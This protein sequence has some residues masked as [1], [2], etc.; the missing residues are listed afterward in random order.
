MYKDNIFKSKI[1]ISN[2]AERIRF[3]FENTLLGHMCIYTIVPVF[4]RC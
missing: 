4:S 3:E 2:K 1:F